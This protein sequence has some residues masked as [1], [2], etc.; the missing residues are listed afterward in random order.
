ML[1]WCVRNISYYYYQ[2]WKPLCCFICLCFD[3]IRSRRDFFPNSS[4]LLTNKIKLLN[5]KKPK[6]KTKRPLY[7]QTASIQTSYKPYPWKQTWIYGTVAIMRLQCNAI[8][9][10]HLHI[11]TDTVIV[12]IQVYTI[13]TSTWKLSWLY[14]LTSWA[15]TIY[16]YLIISPIS[17]MSASF[18]KKW[19]CS[20]AI[21]NEPA[22]Y[23]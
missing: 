6:K 22:V 4:R 2:C 3:Q 19:K 16:I 10:L 8:M 5:I 13:K 12:Q 20:K 14:N 1:I 23:I 18:R 9:L 11:F 15:S 17:I 21:L 7:E